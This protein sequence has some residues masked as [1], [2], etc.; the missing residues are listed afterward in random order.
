MEYNW[1][2]IK[3]K[4]FY[5]MVKP[6]FASLSSDVLWWRYEEKYVMMMEQK[7]DKS[8][9]KKLK[10]FY[11]ELQRKKTNL[12]QENFMFNQCGENWKNFPCRSKVFFKN[13]L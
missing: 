8:K 6:L 10:L 9:N 4:R 2:N 11:Q 1:G 7:L 5:F 13:V 12:I 3:M